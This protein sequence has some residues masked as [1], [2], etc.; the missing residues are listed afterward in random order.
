MSLLINSY[1]ENL[2][3]KTGLFY[4]A[5]KF[6]AAMSI[7]KNGYRFRQGTSGSTKYISALL[8]KIKTD[9][10]EHNLYI[11]LYFLFKAL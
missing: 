5:E 2:D 8:R 11:E 9:G 4:Q 7:I 1:F 10:V 3:P 6:D